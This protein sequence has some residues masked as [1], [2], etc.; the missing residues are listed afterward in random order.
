MIACGRVGRCHGR[1][2][3][4]VLRIKN[5]TGDERYR[6]CLRRRSEDS[7]PEIRKFCKVTKTEQSKQMEVFPHVDNPTREIRAY[8]LA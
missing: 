2:D 7:M 4:E 1:D 5:V 6:I 3:L 8:T